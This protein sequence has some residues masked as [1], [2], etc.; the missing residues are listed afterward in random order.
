M[1]IAALLISGITVAAFLPLQAFGHDTW[2]CEMPSASVKSATRHK[3]YLGS[4]KC[5]PD[6]FTWKGLKYKI[7]EGWVERGTQEKNTMLCLRLDQIPPGSFGF[8]FKDEEILKKQHS[9]FWACRNW[10]DNHKVFT[11]FIPD[12]TLPL[13][14]EKGTI[15][16][17]ADSGTPFSLR[18]GT[19]FV[20]ID[21]T[22]E[23]TN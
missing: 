5:S 9:Q 23:K 20:N 16:I 6:A 18:G 4:V 2:P 12:S 11:V 14:W 19:D 7:I 3:T 1:N 17:Q 8:T 22:A 15:H 13:F 21:L 10:F